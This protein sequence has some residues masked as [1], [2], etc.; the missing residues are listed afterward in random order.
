LGA[1]VVS[2]ERTAAAANSS[3]SGLR[4]DA[5]AAGTRVLAMVLA[6]A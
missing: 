1:A 6:A 2:G 5:P 4:A 3:G